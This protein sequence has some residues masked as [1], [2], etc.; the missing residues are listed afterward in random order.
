MSSKDR[1]C[2]LP[3]AWIARFGRGTAT[4]RAGFVDDCTRCAR[5]ARKKWMNFSE[6]ADYPVKQKGREAGG[7]DLRAAQPMATC[8][9]QNICYC[10][11]PHASR[12]QSAMPSASGPRTQDST[13]SNPACSFF[14][15]GSPMASPREWQ[16]PLLESK[17]VILED[18]PCEIRPLKIGLVVFIT[19]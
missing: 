4:S 18:R 16:H 7:E 10:I 19:W 17:R 2:Q 6:W 13:E 14:L 3:P 12:R 5:R 15:A 1:A 9:I 8:P 11:A